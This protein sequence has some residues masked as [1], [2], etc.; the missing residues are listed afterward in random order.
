MLPAKAETTGMLKLFPEEELVHILM[1]GAQILFRQAQSQ[2][3][4]LL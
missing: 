3:V 2:Q 1:H 4:C